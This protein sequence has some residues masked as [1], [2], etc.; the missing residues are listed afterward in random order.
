MAKVTPSIRVYDTDDP[1]QEEHSPL[2]ICERLTHIAA[3]T[4]GDVEDSLRQVMEHLD[5]VLGLENF[6]NAPDSPRNMRISEDVRNA[7]DL[8]RTRFAESLVDVVNLLE[9]AVRISTQARTLVTSI[10]G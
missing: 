9:E 7:S 6:P 10:V 4:Q 5:A 3:R 2:L 1:L 8:A